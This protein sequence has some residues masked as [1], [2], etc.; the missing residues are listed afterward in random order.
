MEFG[1]DEACCRAEVGASAGFSS[2][3]QVSIYEQDNGLLLTLKL[4]QESV[5]RGNAG[6]ILESTE[7]TVTAVTAV[8]ADLAHGSARHLGST[9]PTTFSIENGPIPSKLAIR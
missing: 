2:S 4:G 6:I 8:I 1:I 5:E 9:R 7:L 3:R